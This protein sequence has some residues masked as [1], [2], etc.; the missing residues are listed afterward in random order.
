L[1][2]QFDEEASF[3][4]F[5]S[6]LETFQAEDGITPN[7]YVGKHLTFN[8]KIVNRIELCRFFQRSWRYAIIELDEPPWCWIQCYEDDESTLRDI[9]EIVGHQPK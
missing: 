4:L 7:E 6:L 2:C 8:H 1:K 3:E 9:N 5:F